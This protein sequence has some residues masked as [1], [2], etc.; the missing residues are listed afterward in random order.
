MKILA[1]VTRSLIRVYVV[2][3]QVKRILR[4][5]Q[6]QMRKIMSTI[7]PIQHEMVIL[8]P[9]QRKICWQYDKM[10]KLYLYVM[11]VSLQFA[12]DREK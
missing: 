8:L 11:Y 7:I 5:P 12:C 10:R 6:A 3:K 2:R 9:S 1:A 4:H